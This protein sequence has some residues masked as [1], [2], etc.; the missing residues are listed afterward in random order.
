MAM[1]A[2]TASEIMTQLGHRQM[3]TSQKY[4]HWAADARQA[5]AERA[6]ATALA[7]MAAATGKAKGKVV[8]LKG[9]RR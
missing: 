3:A 5:L 2:A 1:N 6:A 7:G 8:K 9:G 4:V